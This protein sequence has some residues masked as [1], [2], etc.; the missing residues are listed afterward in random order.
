L[1]R[2]LVCSLAL[3]VAGVAI[4]TEDPAPSADVHAFY[5][6]WYATP[7]VDGRWEHWNHQILLRE[8]EGPRHQP[9]DDIGA[10]FYPQAGL[11]SSCS[12]EAVD[13]HFAELRRAGCGV[14][15]VSWWGPQDGGDAAL[16]LVFAAA[17]RHGVEIAFHIEP[18]RGRGAATTR[19]A[20][21]QLL[22][23]WGDHQAL[24]RRGG[25]PV[26][27]VYDSYLTPPAEWATLLRPGGELSIRGTRHDV[28]AIGLWV[29]RDDGEAL[30]AGGFDGVY[31]YFAT[32]GFTFGATTSNWP[33]LAAFARTHGLLFVPC[34]GPGYADLRVRPWNTPNQR[35]REQGAY[36]DR[37]WQ[38]AIAA[39]P[40][41]VGVTSYN[42]WHEGTQIEPAVPLAIPGFAYFD[43]GDLGPGWYLDRTRHWVEA[44]TRGEGRRP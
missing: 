26:V 15:V 29:G 36:Y 6:A 28:V 24:H 21:V 32:D 25:R 39:Q 18:F 40:P 13:R 14:A 42:E 31:T 10:S 12:A 22:E 34:V 7:A 8:G 19:E 9:P 11:Y 1:L 30:F 20:L 3:V 43:Y 41:I 17:A 23:R 4:A 38:A 44:F 5:Y 16:T 33:A 27:Y 35:D 37:T 2:I